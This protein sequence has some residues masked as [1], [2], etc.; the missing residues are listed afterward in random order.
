[1]DVQVGVP[2]GSI[3]GP[4]FFLIYINDLL[5][6]LTSYPKLLVDNTSLFSTVA[7]PNVTANKTN[8][9]LHN[10]ERCAYQWKMSFNANPSKQAQEV[11]FSRR[12]KVTAHPAPVF[13]NNPAY[14]H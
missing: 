1:M 10:T 4:L 14:Q 8:T 3:H 12:I 5:Y 6:N 7:D 9:D 11:I 13:N 2:Q